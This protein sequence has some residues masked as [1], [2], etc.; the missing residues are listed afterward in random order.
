VPTKLLPRGFQSEVHCLPKMNHK[1][2]VAKDNDLRKDVETIEAEK[3]KFEN[4]AEHSFQELQVQNDALH[5]IILELQKRDELVDSESEKLQE[6]VQALEE[7]V[8]ALQKAQD[9]ELMVKEGC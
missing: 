1:I 5:N 9:I 6:R 2:C 4:K 8:Q 3:K 7:T